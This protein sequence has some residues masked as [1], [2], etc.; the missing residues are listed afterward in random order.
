MCR[1]DV[2]HIYRIRSSC[3]FHSGNNWSQINGH[4]LTSVPCTSKEKEVENTMPKATR[5]KTLSNQNICLNSGKLSWS[6]A[7]LL[8]SLLSLSTHESVPAQLCSK[9]RLN[10]ECV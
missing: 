8:F 2:F 3:D 10:S 5:R 6:S 9:P 7:E 4:A 1:K